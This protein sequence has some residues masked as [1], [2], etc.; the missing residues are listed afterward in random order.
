MCR[1]FGLSKACIVSAQWEGESDRAMLRLDHASG[2]FQE[3]ACGRHP[4]LHV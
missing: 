3:L 2:R 4:V 1:V